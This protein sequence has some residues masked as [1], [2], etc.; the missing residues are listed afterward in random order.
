[1]HKYTPLLAQLALMILEV[2]AI[3]SITYG[4]WSIYAPAGWIACGS[5][6]WL[7]LNVLSRNTTKIS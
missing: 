2:I 7:E 1:M 5:L 6:I 3:G 4:A